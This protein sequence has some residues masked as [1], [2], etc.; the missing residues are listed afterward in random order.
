MCHNKWGRQATGLVSFL[1]TGQP[2][3][4]LNSDKVGGRP[5]DKSLKENRI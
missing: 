2:G 5:E 4:R 1:F 3:C